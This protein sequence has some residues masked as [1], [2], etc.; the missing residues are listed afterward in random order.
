MRNVTSLGYIPSF[1]SSLVYLWKVWTKYEKMKL[2]KIDHTNL[3]LD[4]GYQYVITWDANESQ[5][6]STCL[7]KQKKIK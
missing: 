1:S 4:Y 5:Q 7:K 2:N 6:S 3:L